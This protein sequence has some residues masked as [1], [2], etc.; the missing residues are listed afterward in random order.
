MDLKCQIYYYKKYC[1]ETLLLYFDLC[2][3]HKLCVSVYIVWIP[4]YKNDTV[5]QYYLSGVLI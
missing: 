2:S 3:V 4:Q 5:I 1:D